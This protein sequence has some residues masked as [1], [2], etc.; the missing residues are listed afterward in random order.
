MRNI[1]TMLGVV[2]VLALGTEAASAQVGI[3]IG[4]GAAPVERN[5][6]IIRDRTRSRDDDDD[7]RVVRRRVIERREV[8][9]EPRVVERRVIR[10][11]APCRTVI[12]VVRNRDTGV[13]V[14]RRT[15]VCG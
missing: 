8:E 5:T 12:R 11:R 13:T 15:R 3:Q 14:R 9:D 7:D 4:P 2:G 1:W 10:S 6:T